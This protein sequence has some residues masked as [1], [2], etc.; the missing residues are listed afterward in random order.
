MQFTPPSCHL[1]SLRHTVFSSVTFPQMQIMHYRFET[2]KVVTVT[3]I[4]C[5]RTRCSLGGNYQHFT[6][7]LLPKFSQCFKKYNPKLE[8]FGSFE[9]FVYTYQT[10][11]RHMQYD[12]NICSQSFPRLDNRY[13]HQYQNKNL[14]FK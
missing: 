12:S 1:Q 6:K 3:V 10:T 8:A 14:T 5:R 4:S 2:Q 7:K 9:T 11:R 13:L